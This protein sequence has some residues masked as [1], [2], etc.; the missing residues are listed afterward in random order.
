[1][2]LAIFC[3]LFQLFQKTSIL[4]DIAWSLPMV[5]TGMESKAPF[6]RVYRGGDV[7]LRHEAE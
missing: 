7:A 5:C 3:K 2:I 1:M 6:R 4:R